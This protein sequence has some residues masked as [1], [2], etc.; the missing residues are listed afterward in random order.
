[1]PEMLDTVRAVVIM[2]GPMN[3]YQE[4]EFPF[5]KEEDIFIKKLIKAKIPCLGVCLGSQLLAKSLGAKVMKAKAPEI[6]WGDIRFSKDAVKDPLFSSLED[7]KLRV[8]QWHEDTFDLPSNAVHL[9]SSEWVP[10]QA[11]RY[12]DRFYGFQFHVEVDRLMLEDWFKKSND[13]AEI[14]EEYDRYQEKLSVITEVIYG[15]FFSEAPVL[16]N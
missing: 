1:M 12:E 4:A 5:L 9:A 3:V 7:S 13:L 11:F 8:L 2:G 10:N 14:L 16:N 6:G 15:N